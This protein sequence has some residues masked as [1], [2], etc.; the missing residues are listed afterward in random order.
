MSCINV[1]VAGTGSAINPSRGQVS[2]MLD[3]GGSQIVVDVG[4][5]APNVYEGLSYRVD[6]VE[7]YIV[8]HAHY[9]HIC[10]LPMVAF[11]KTFRS[12]EP[13][14]KVYTVPSAS[15]LVKQLLEPIAQGRVGYDV[16]IVTSRSQLDI[17]GARVRFL[18]AQHTIETVGV[19]V[20]YLGLKV[21]VSSD[22]RPTM[23]FKDEAVGA[24]LAI[25]EAT[26]PSGMEGEAIKTGH[27]TVGEAVEQ[28][29]G[30]H[31][32]ILYHL[33]QWS[34]MEALEV[35]KRY[36]RILVVPDGSIVRI[37]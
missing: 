33:T 26:L 8:T 30:A 32:A 34:E 2:V 22:T 21:L 18:E 19:I 24:H 20:E 12:R 10:G 25:H 14:L 27:S 9:D 36:K 3:I 13:D 7:H 6:E 1:L 5:Q 17:G 35:S 37:C 11:I 31:Q 28:V 16:R 29:L 23:R 15:H 4:C